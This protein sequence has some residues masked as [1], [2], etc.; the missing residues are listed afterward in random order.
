MR[1]RKVKQCRTQSPSLRLPTISS[2][3]DLKALLNTKPLLTTNF[4][5]HSLKIFVPLTNLDIRKKFFSVRVISYW[6]RLSAE[7]VEARSLSIFKRH[8]DDELGQALYAHSC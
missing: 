1:R 2:R 7:A 4:D 8:L 3:L 6:N 5:E